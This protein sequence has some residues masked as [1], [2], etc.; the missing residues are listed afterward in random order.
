MG[1]RKWRQHAGQFIARQVL[2]EGP[3]LRRAAHVIRKEL[4]E[5]V[6]NYEE[7]GPILDMADGLTIDDLRRIFEHRGR[8][9][10]VN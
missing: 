9:P 8:S 1:L 4:S 6:Q 10:E 2:A 7:E 5:A 3:G